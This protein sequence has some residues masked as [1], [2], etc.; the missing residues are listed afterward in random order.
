MR[1]CYCMIRSLPKWNTEK[2]RQEERSFWKSNWASGLVFS[3]AIGCF[4]LYGE[5]MYKKSKVCA[6]LK[7]KVQKVEALKRLLL[8]EQEELT[9]ELSS[10]LDDDWLEMVLKKRLGVV[11]E[12]QMKVYFKKDE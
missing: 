2:I 12:G 5:A 3:V 8:E 1:G 7:D 6:E 4:S 10:H 11:P 9:S